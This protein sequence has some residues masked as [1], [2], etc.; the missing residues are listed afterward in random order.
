MVVTQK[1][2]AMIQDLGL[3]AKVIVKSNAIFPAGSF[4]RFNASGLSGVRLS[5]DESVKQLT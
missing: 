3:T 1:S 2:Y 5:K 4:G